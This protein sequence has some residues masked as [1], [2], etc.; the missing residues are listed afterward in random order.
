MMDARQRADLDRHITGNYGEDQ[1]KYTEAPGLCD[2]C[3][4][5]YEAETFGFGVGV[6]DRSQMGV[7]V[8]QFLE[9]AADMAD[10]D[11]DKVDDPEIPCACTG[12]GREVVK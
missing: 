5:F 8:E 3:Y 9:I 4:E 11:C 7:T 12:H 10:H 2:S 1:F 6:A